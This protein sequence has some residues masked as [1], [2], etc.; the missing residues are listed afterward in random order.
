MLTRRETKKGGELAI[1]RTVTRP[2][3]HA[4]KNGSSQN[5]R[6]ALYAPQKMN[7]SSKETGPGKRAE[8]SSGRHA[9]LRMRL[10]FA[11]RTSI[12]ADTRPATPN[13]WIIR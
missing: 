2:S 10:V 6:G 13:A 7:D 9:L 1:I 8:S 12:G 3:R 4:Q 5:A 11:R